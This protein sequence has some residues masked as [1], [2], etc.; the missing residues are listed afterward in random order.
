MEKLAV[1]LCCG[2]GG[3]SLG[4]SKAGFSVVVAVDN[5]PINCQYHEKNFPD[6]KVLER[7]LTNLTGSEVRAESDLGT[8]RINLVF[9][10]PP[11]QGFSLIG[12]RDR[13]DPR[14]SILHEFTRIAIELD[15]KMIVIENVLGLASGYGRT[16]LD[17][18]KNKLLTAGYISL[19]ELKLN[20]ADFGVPQARRRIF[21][22]ASKG[23]LNF[24][25]IPKPDF[26]KAT[27]KDAIANIGSGQPRSL[28]LKTITELFSTE[29]S[30][31]KVLGNHKLPVHSKSVIKRFRKTIPG[32]SEPIS[33]YPRLDWSGVCPTIRAGTLPDKGSFM[34]ARPIH[35]D[36]A[37]CI[38]V[39]E[40]AR[41]HSYPDTFQFHNSHWHGFRQI[42]NSVPPMLAYY[43]AKALISDQ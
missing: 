10:G 2:V 42:G 1:D 18:V 8:K 6:C 23:V 35:P 17:Q 3:M 26:N 27:V 21:L 31:T 13:D 7:D 22:I 38:T 37:R 43:V 11:C 41:L 5:E 25:E 28:Y 4:F 19:L 29:N 15:P 40:A 34:A 16:H 14:S 9:G 39:R 30:S 24:K 33:R 32:S 12:K 36:G 20:A